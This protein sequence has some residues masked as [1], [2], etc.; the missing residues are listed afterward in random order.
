MIPTP[1]DA[2]R[3]TGAWLQVPGDIV[4]AARPQCQAR[5]Y[6]TASDCV[7]TREGDAVRIASGAG[8]YHPLYYAVVGTLALPF[9]GTA[10]LYVM[11]LATAALAL[12]LVALA[13][14]A[15]RTWARSRIALLGPVV[16]FTPVVVYSCSI[17]S[18]NGVEMAAGLAFWA[19]AVGLLVADAHD[20]RR[21]SVMAAVSEPRC[22]PCDRWDRSGACSRR[23]WCWSP[24]APSPDGFGSCSVGATSRFRRQWSP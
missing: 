4:D 5:V 13:L 19:A 3:G 7:G 11:R 12:A 18:P 2:T 16:A 15:L 10:A 23:S 21:L 8:R 20:V 14:G 9:H 6:T 22:A 17:V 24:S 1:S